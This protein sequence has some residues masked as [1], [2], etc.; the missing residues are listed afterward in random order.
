MVR[1][2]AGVRPRQL[3]F[4]GAH[5]ARL[6][7]LGLPWLCAP[8]AARARLCV[9]SVE[10]AARPGAAPDR[11]RFPIPLANVTI[12][13]VSVLTNADGQVCASSRPSFLP[14]LPSLLFLL[15]VFSLPQ[16]SEARVLVKIM[17][18]VPAARRKFS[19]DV[20]ERCPGGC[21]ATVWARQYLRAASSEARIE[22]QPRPVP[23]FPAENWRFEGWAVQAQTANVPGTNIAFLAHPSA[24]RPPSGT[25]VFLTS[26]ANS[27][28]GPGWTQGY[29]QQQG[30][31]PATA[32]PGQ[33]V[34][35]SNPAVFGTAFTGRMIVTPDTGRLLM[36]VGMDRTSSPRNE[37]GTTSLLENKN[38]E[39]PSHPAD[40]IAAE[41][42]GRIR[43]DWRGA[44]TTKHEDYRLHVFEKGYD[45]DGT[46]MKN[47]LFVIP[48]GVSDR[49]SHNAAQLSTA[50]ILN[51]TNLRSGNLRR[52]KLPSSTACAKT[53]DATAACR[54]WV[55][56]AERS[57]CFLKDADFC[58]NPAADS[59]GG[60][61]HDGN[62]PCSSGIKVDAK[63]KSCKP[64]AASHIGRACGR[65]GFASSSLLG[66]YR[67]CRW[68]ELPEP[69]GLEDP[70][71]A[72][73]NC[74]SWPGDVP[75]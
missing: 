17:L 11:I 1:A 12:C 47:W 4:A 18:C 33:L 9:G 28:A 59:C 5:P 56:D 73:S 24:Y 41:G 34:N 13:G 63:A 29:W 66:P 16:L 10:A 31:V 50:S 45:C 68:L 70:G 21:V 2:A 23:G 54:A 75:P 26:T 60:C 51:S 15:P 72:E 42:D 30:S 44:P 55:F 3:R 53:C 19:A 52:E 8:P 35:A 25:R 38:V 43:V 20:G 74:D 22:L 6:L 71:G 27:H 58:I 67:Y 46:D 69:Q 64:G 7:L 61:A 32:V 65:M 57:L 14:S 36:L 37:T 48:D 39:D 49:E 40:W 62:C